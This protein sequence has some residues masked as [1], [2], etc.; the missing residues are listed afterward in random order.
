MAAATENRQVG[1]RLR[2]ARDRST[3]PGGRTQAA[4][5]T[6]RDCANGT[7]PPPEAR[8]HVTITEIQHPIGAQ[9]VERDA[10]PPRRPRSRSARLRLAATWWSGGWWSALPIAVA[11]VR[12]A[13]SD[14]VPTGDDAYFTVRSRDVLTRHHPLLGAWSSGSVDLDTPINNLGPLQLDLLA[15]FTRWTPMGGTAIGVA[16]INIAAV[17]AIAWIVRRAGGRGAVL[18]AMWRSAC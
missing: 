12:A 13:A 17:V 9:R 16:V 11:A 8:R 2:V 3:R 14:W 10:T 15:P 18:P 6:G 4:S 7:W 5:L 1:S